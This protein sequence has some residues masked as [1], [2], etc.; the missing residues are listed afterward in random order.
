M[1][2]FIAPIVIAI[3]VLIMLLAYGY[4]FLSVVGIYF[5]PLTNIVIA[6]IILFLVIALI[7]VLIQRIKELKEENEDDLSKY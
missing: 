6:G 3:V 2:K 7:R 5:S 1:M 4:G